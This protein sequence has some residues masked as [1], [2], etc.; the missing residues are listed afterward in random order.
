MSQN[1]V[2]CTTQR[3]HYV[4]ITRTKTNLALKLVYKLKVSSDI[5]LLGGKNGQP[6]AACNELLGITQFGDNTRSLR[7]PIT[8]LK[9]TG[10]ESQ[11][12]TDITSPMFVFPTR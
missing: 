10:Q 3:Y 5:T 8:S 1:I 6:R 11:F 12:W 9:T 4:R 7:P 2:S